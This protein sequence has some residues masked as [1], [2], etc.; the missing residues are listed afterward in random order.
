MPS[1]EP[2][3]GA[4][5]IPRK[6]QRVPNPHPRDRSTG[7]LMDLKEEEGGELTWADAA[8]VVEERRRQGGVE[9]PVAHLRLAAG[10][11]QR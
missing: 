11:E 10:G 9:V 6:K 4:K 8:T 5:S 2:R 3:T 7:G 1:R